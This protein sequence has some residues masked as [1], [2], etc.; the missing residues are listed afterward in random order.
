MRFLAFISAYALATSYVAADELVIGIGVNDF[1][2]SDDPSAYTLVLEYHLAPFVENH[3]VLYNW[4]GAFQYSEISDRFAGVGINAFHNIRNGS[5][6]IEGSFMPGYYTQGS[7]GNDLGGHFQ[8]RT[9]FSVGYLLN[10]TA[11]ISVSIDHISNG[12]IES[13]NP[14]KESV[15]A[16]FIY[17]F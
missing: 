7:R 10:P 2:E 17:K 1:A 13:P 8:F 15:A 9:L 11:R 12:G 14:G 3:K 5:W 16:R 6:F 4:A